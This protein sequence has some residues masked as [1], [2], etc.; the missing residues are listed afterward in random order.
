MQS[1]CN[2]PEGIKPALSFKA[3]HK[4]S[5]TLLYPRYSWGIHLPV[6][7]MCH[8]SRAFSELS[9]LFLSETQIVLV[10]IMK[11]HSRRPCMYV[12][13]QHTFMTSFTAIYCNCFSRELSAVFSQVKI[14]AADA[15]SLRGTTQ[16]YVTAY[17]C[18]CWHICQLQRHYCV[19]HNSCLYSFTSYSHCLFDI[20][21]VG[22]LGRTFNPI[23]GLEV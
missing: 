4:F 18:I 16:Q 10:W 9:I 19:H 23:G 7:H 21:I 13:A 2:F 3:A 15:T 11:R 14:I 1:L 20:V 6:G 12:S 22:Y 17:I 8:S 5:M